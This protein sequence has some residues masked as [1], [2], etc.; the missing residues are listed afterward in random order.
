MPVTLEGAGAAFLADGSGALLNGI[1]AWIDLGES[2]TFAATGGFTWCAWVRYDT[3]T[4]ATVDGPYGTS[5]LDDNQ[6]LICQFYTTDG[7]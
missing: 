2:F 3:Q 6:Y 1:D 7:V 4:A 5:L